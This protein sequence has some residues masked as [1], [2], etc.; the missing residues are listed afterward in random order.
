MEIYRVTFIGHR[1]IEGNYGLEKRLEA[2]VLDLLRSKEY[3]EFYVGRNG[4]FDTSAASVV[5]RAQEKQG[6]E[7]SSLILVLPYLVADVPYY[8][9]FYDEIIIPVGKSHP[10]SAITKR[11]RWMIEN[12]DLLIAFV[13]EGRLGGAMSAL[14]YAEKRSIKIIN[15]K[16]EFFS[17][18]Y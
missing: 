15:L 8:E 9:R 4:D 13:E 14:K 2:L 6:S 18:T 1:Y 16:A 12:A 17:K 11:N 3:V 10:K 7:N 5:K